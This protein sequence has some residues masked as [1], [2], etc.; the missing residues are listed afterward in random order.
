MY[1]Q[2]FPQIFRCKTQVGFIKEGNHVDAGWIVA[3]FSQQRGG[4]YFLVWCYQDVA[5]VGQFKLLGLDTGDEGFLLH[6]MSKGSGN[7]GSGLFQIVEL[8]GILLGG[9][10]GGFVEDGID[11]KRQVGIECDLLFLL[12]QIETCAQCDGDG[13]VLS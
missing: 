8:H 3:V 1:A 13:A 11:E 12:V 6:H 2:R 9:Q 4:G 10:A 7:G 5:V